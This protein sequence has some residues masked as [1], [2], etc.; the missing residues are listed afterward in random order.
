MKSNVATINGRKPIGSYD[1]IT[2]T[3]S[4][5]ALTSHRLWKA[6]GAWTVDTAYLDE[7]WPDCLTVEI[8]CQTDDTV[9]VASVKSIRASTWRQR[10]GS[11]H[12]D[13]FGEQ[14]ALPFQY[15]R[16]KKE[17]DAQWV[18]YHRRKRQQEEE[19]HMANTVIA[20]IVEH[21][22]VAYDPKAHNEYQLSLLDLRAEGYD[23]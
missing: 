23:V 2:Q 19:T 6:G 17:P 13:R 5:W 20:D 22:S 10:D 18:E 8:Y 9:Y 12:Q 3:Y 7:I 14:Y 11:L 15:W 16:K 21:D 4:K 1:P